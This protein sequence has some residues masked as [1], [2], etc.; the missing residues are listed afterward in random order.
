MGCC[1]PAPAKGTNVRHRIVAR[2]ASSLP[3]CMY[4]L[5]LLDMGGSVSA[6]ARPGNCGYPQSDAALQP[7][8][9]TPPYRHEH[10]FCR[11]PQDAVNTQWFALVAARAHPRTSVR[12]D[13]RAVH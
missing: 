6:A 1:A 3:G 7:L 4:L 12:G 10:F 11:Q 9:P 2:P 13:G 5:L 8:I